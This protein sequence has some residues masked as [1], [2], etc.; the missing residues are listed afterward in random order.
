MIRKQTYIKS[1]Q[2]VLLKNKAK[3]LGLTE[4][5]LIRCAIDEHLKTKFAI[6]KDTSAWET[7]K[8]FIISRMKEENYSLQRGW[9]REE[10]YGL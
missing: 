4:A 6:H 5:E 1:H 2:E 8:Q 10:L 7:E 3:A 9:R